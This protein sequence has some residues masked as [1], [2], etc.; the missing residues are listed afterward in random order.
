MLPCFIYG[1]SFVPHPPQCSCIWCPCFHTWCEFQDILWIFFLHTCDSN[2]VCVTSGKYSVR[3]NKIL[4]LGA[5]C[6]RLIFLISNVFAV[7]SAHICSPFTHYILNSLDITQIY[8]LD[9]WKEMVCMRF[10]HIVL[11]ICSC[12]NVKKQSC[13]VSNEE[14]KRRG[15]N[16]T[17]LDLKFPLSQETQRTV[18]VLRTMAIV[19][20]HSIRFYCQAGSFLTVMLSCVRMICTL[21]WFL[22]TGSMA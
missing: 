4:A 13:L 20:S 12:I 8:I 5:A 6:R 7:L 10:C 2:R 19:S 16:R 22:H 21:L 14:Y 1:F 15:E 3:C 9:S 11:D 17:I 18:F